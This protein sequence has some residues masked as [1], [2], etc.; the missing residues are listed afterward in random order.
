[1]WHHP[2]G[3]P[4][5]FTPDYLRDLNTMHE[6]EKILTHEQRYG[7]SGIGAWLE[8]VLSRDLDKANVR[9]FDFLHATAAQRAEAFLKAIG[10]WE[11][12]F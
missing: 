3:A 12:T 11:E 2:D 9:H 10:Q 8:D 6:A 7:V 5:G 4:I 1:M